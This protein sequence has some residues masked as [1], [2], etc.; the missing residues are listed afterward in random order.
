[1]NITT[2][3]AVVIIGVVVS[4]LGVHFWIKKKVKSGLR[5]IVFVILG[6]VFFLAW[7]LSEDAG[8]REAENLRRMLQG[9]APTYA[10]EMQLLGHPSLPLEASANDPT[11]LAL[12]RRQIDWLKINPFVNDI[13]TFRKRPDGKIV[14]MVD[15]ETDYD[16]NGRY[17]GER[18]QRTK[19][20]EVYEEADE[21]LENAFKG[22]PSFDDEPYTDRWGVWVSA[23]TPIFRE[24]GSVDAVLG[25]DYSAKSWVS[26]IARRKASVIVPFFLLLLVIIVSSGIIAF[27]KAEVAERRRLE[28]HL[29]QS[30]KMETVGTLAGGIA[31]DLNNQL[32]PLVG[33]LDIIM[34][35]T[36]PDSADR[37]MLV[38]AVKA[39]NRCADVVQRL[40][41]FSKPSTGKKDVISVKELLGELGTLF[42]KIAP[43]TIQLTIDCAHDTWSLEGNAS[44]L[45]TVLMNLAVN[46]R[47][48]MPSGGKLTIRTQN[49]EATSDE[50]LQA[51]DRCR[52]IR[53]D[54]TDT[55]IGMTPAISS[56][57][58][59]PFFT[60]K[61][62]SKGTGLGLAMVFNIVKEHRGRI[63]VTSETGKG[64]TFS[65]YFPASA[66]T[67]AE[68]LSLKPRDSN[69]QSVLPRGSET[70]LFVD[71]EES[72]RVM[73]K[74]FL[75]R[76]GYRAILAKDGQEA[77]DIYR[78]QKDKIDLVIL[79]MTMPRLTGREALRR[80]LE[81]KPQAKVLLCSGF[82]VE[83]NP[84][85][86]IAAGAKQYIAKPYN[87]RIFADGIRQALDK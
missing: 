43:S 58:F 55:G 14:L 10:Y 61:E 53:I 27:M 86:L 52:T 71:D 32:T 29:L 4:S 33:Y 7:I 2:V 82:T 17:E 79:D 13:Y 72:L 5:P 59:E 81:I 22:I 56:R 9:L 35:Q 40:L 57:I 69:R 25:V 78:Q 50:A 8:H 47:D 65:L 42:E 19:I 67:A 6:F 28:T 26:A 38:E 21:K 1:M 24:D 16:H 63:H 60:T 85:E 87:I 73:G 70:V 46:A 84:K 34:G 83:G 54:V 51:P 44:E 18:E 80:I 23:Y 68:G 75:D 62:R 48:A 3:W 76:L 36:K 31:H 77:V 74:A 30:Q 64:S 49:I 20:G 12:I 39:A 45:H 66:S 37:P 41:S 11:Y 15:S